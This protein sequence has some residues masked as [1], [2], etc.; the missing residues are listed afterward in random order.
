MIATDMIRLPEFDEVSLPADALSECDVQGFHTRFHAQVEIETPSFKNNHR[1]VL[2]NRGWVGYLPMRDD[3]WLHLEPKVPI[4]N[5]FRMLEYAYDLKSF[6]FL[7]GLIGCDSLQD[8]YSRLAMLLAGRIRT[9]IRRGIFRTYVDHHD[10]LAVIK[11]APDIQ[12][13]AARPWDPHLYCT[14]DE[15]TSDL[16][17]NQILAWTLDRILA[18]GICT[19]DARRMVG[20]AYREMLPMCATIPYSAADCEGRSYTRLNEDYRELHALC[21][22]FLDH[23]GPHHGSGGR[24]MV[25][26]KVDMARLFELYVARWLK[27][28]L[29]PGIV[30]ESQ[31]NVQVA[32]NHPLRFVP[33]LVLSDRE[34]GE[35]L[36]VLDTKYKGHA[37]PT[38][39]DVSQVIAYAHVL[40]CREAVLV[41]P[42]DVI[43]P[44]RVLKRGVLVRTAD[45]ALCAEGNLAGQSTQL[46]K[47]ELSR[48]SRYPNTHPIAPPKP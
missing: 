15:H 2:K 47:L 19:D 3:L 24:T 29:D 46:C 20:K 45:F 14:F 4:A 13:A 11:G 35:I 36:C 31:L 27:R 44:L 40:G 33:D 6:E 37:S 21:R 28:H 48:F 30:V 5:L 43:L 17:E 9:R 23:A 16:P 38:P 39:A 41:Y 42:V 22:F 34:T 12:K 7:D 1:W 8:L 18:D 25:P 26:F 10:R 32:P